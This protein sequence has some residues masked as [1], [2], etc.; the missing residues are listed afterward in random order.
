MQQ[1]PKNFSSDLTKQKSLSRNELKFEQFKNI[2]NSINDGNL[3]AKIRLIQDREKFYLT[4]PETEWL[5]DNYKND[6][7]NGISPENSVYRTVFL[8]YMQKIIHKIV[9]GYEGLPNYDYDLLSSYAMECVINCV[10]HY[11]KDKVSTIHKYIYM[12]IQNKIS[13]HLKKQA[14]NV[15]LL[16]GETISIEAEILRNKEK[17]NPDEILID[18]TDEDEQMKHND[19][20]FVMEGLSHLPPSYQFI[21]MKYYGF[22]GEPVSLIPLSKSLDRSHETI[23]QIILKS[24]KILKCVSGVKMEAEDSVRV[25]RYKKQYYHV[26]TEAEFNT[27]NKSKTL[28]ELVLQNKLMSNDQKQLCTNN[29]LLFHN[30]SV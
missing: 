17:E 1:A 21:I 30:K 4:I 6:I 7:D 15:C 9:K 8:M 20:M 23:R 28:T 16:D 25:R 14:K 11:D 24:I 26:F 12:S 19:K 29:V 18:K 13:V 3:I 5:L 2:I 22:Y 10:D 27:I